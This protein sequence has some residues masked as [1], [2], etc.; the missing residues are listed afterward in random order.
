[1]TT[2]PNVR[3]LVRIASPRPAMRPRS[4]RAD[5]RIWTGISGLVALVLF[6]TV[7]AMLAGDPTAQDAPGRLLPPSWTHPFGTDEFRRD[8]LARTA[9]GLRVSL[10]TSVLAVPAGASLGTALGLVVGYTGGWPDKL[11]MRALDAWMAFPG[12]LAAFAIVAILG[13]GMLSIGVALALFSFPVFARVSR[14]QTMAERQ[15]D[16]VLAARAIGAGPARILMRHVLPNTVA[17]LVTQLAL[18]LTASILIA[19]ALSFLGLGERPPTPSLGGLLNS[20]RNYIREAWW[21]VTFPGAVLAL[22]LLSLNLLSDA[23]ADH[24]SRLK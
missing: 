21:Y 22:L 10:L 20:S 3:A 16:Y 14:A 5:R 13:P 17:P 19:S 11:S 2:I 24:L 23:V 1:M 18:T 4:L 6:C 12:V 9:T 7:G 8:L 15:R